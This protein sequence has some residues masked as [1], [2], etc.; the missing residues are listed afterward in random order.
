RVS[1]IIPVRNRPK[2]FEQFYQSLVNSTKIPF[3]LIIVDDASD[4]ATKALIEEIATNP[5]IPTFVFTNET[6]QGYARTCN[7]GMQEARG[8]YICLASTDILVTPRWLDKLVK[9]ADVIPE[10]GIFG[11]STNID[12][13]FQI[14]PECANP[15]LDPTTIDI[16]AR[17]LEEQYGDEYKEVPIYAFCYL[18]RS[19][20]ITQIGYYDEQFGIGMG[21][22]IEYR[23]RAHYHGW[24]EIWVKA[25]F[26]YHYGHKS[27]QNEFKHKGAYIIFKEQQKA[28]AEYVIYSRYS[29]RG[30]SMS[31]QLDL[32]I[33]I[34]IHN[35][36]DY[37]RGCVAS[38]LRHT[39]HF[40]LILVND[41]SD[42]D[43][44]KAIVQ[45]AQNDSRIRVLHNDEQLG[46][47]KTCNKGIANAKAPYICLLNSDT[48]V[49]RGWAAKMLAVAATD[50]KIGLIGPTTNFGNKFQEIR[51]AKRIRSPAHVDRHYEKVIEPLTRGQSVCRYLT[52]FCWIMSRKMI[53]DIGVLDE[54]YLLGMY[55]DLE[56][57]ERAWMRGYQ[58]VWVKDSFVYHYGHKS[59]EAAGVNDKRW[60]ERNLKLLEKTRA[61]R[62]ISMK[63]VQKWMKQYAG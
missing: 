37:V 24:K 14:P 47:G 36:I 57:L 4:E 63:Q 41:A 17:R 12:N 55:E 33:V 3:E 43:A 25:A 59:F 19:S 34:P 22:D 28:L 20:M 53:D 7:R 29:S 11:P 35:E 45:I 50:E 5:L 48:L 21:E 38:V 60:K 49:T 56:Y 58:S 61:A 27:I 6:Q 54:Q 62:G 46:F 26:V 16:L 8:E 9:A 30:T 18:L 2:Y 51:A 10:G 42:L 40:E 1:I 39:E 13:K 15:K 32:S 44:Q 23:Y 31:D 52:A